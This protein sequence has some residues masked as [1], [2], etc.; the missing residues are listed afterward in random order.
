MT[1]NGSRMLS[2]V[3]R[4]LVLVAGLIG[5]AELLGWVFDVHSIGGV[6]PS[7]TSMRANT[8]IALLVLAIS[9]SAPRAA[10]VL[11]GA[12]AL[13]IGFVVLVEYAVQRNLGID[14]LLFTDPTGGDFPGR[15]SIATATCMALLGG[16]RLL[17]LFGRA[18]SAQTAALLSLVVGALVLLG[19][20]YGVTSLYSVR[21]FSAMSL[22][23]SIGVV[24]LSLA[25]LASVPGGVL[26]WI[27]L[28][29]DAAALL[30]RRL[31]PVALIGLP[32]IGFACLLAQRDGVVD[33][34]ATLALLVVICAVLV[35][36]VTWAAAFRVARVDLARTDAMQE[37]TY[38]K[39]D[40]ERQV[41]ER[42]LQLQRRRNQVAVLEDRQRIAADLHDIVIQRLFA[43]GMF[44]QGGASDD[45]D[46]AVTRRVNTAIEAMDNA[47]RDLRASIFELGGRVRDSDLTTAVDEVCGESASILGFRP[48]VTVDDP[49]W[50]ADD[51]RDDILAVLREALA[52]VARHADASA[53]DVVLRSA[54]GIVSL[55]VTDDGRGMA[56]HPAR[57]SGTRNMQDRAR[58]RGGDCV[59]TTVEP[60]GTRVSW[61]V[62]VP[63]PA[64]EV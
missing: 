20:A 52:N 14:Q 37:L 54:G 36:L 11:G 44:L 6:S 51:V 34:G 45:D 63:A 61:Q 10:S 48:D 22:P 26:T 28:G 27:V 55:T 56:A 16:A 39:T 59:W 58:Q 23:T 53:A 35:G 1:T 47:I 21:P 43:A 7:L 30:V 2:L 4:A 32:V 41:Q 17:T 38:L 13:G 5:F 18:R 12:I 24:V 62:P 15:L 33:G 19:Y 40:L 25:A 3:T 64:V 49:D 42:A 31:L 9:W 46:P 29:R 60:H 50:E 57:S 8:A